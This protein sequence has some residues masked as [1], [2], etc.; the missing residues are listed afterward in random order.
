M[1][2][3]VG[4]SINEAAALH[5]TDRTTVSNTE[6]A[7]SGVSSDRVRVW[8]ANYACPDAEYIDA[9]AAMARERGTNWWDDYRDVLSAGMLD[10][11][12][13]EHHA[14]GLRHSLA[15]HLPGLL[16]HPDYMRAVFAEAVPAMTSDFLAHQVEFR[17]ARSVVLDAPNRVDC[18]FLIHESALRVSFGGRQV[19]ATQLEHLL[20]QSDRK[21]VNVRIIPFAAG[22]IPN[23]GG[24]TVYAQGPVPALDTVQ[25]DVPTGVTFLHAETHLVNYR[26][27][28]DRMEQRAL[29]P[30]E[31][32]D[33]IRSVLRE[34]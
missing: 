8:A 7:R 5:R 33:F 28:L 19:M 25:I 31:S 13:L 32:Q 29:G 2:E 34:L 30:G 1:R 26:A 24:S 21:N 3:H 20:A 18:S 14:S 6:S 17:R 15:L 9:L 12:E 22:G 11:A 27:V 10:L 4:L 23:A 16:Q